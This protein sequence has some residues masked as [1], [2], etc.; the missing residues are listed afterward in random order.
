MLEIVF[1]G[2]NREIAMVVEGI[3]I[4]L[5]WQFS[6]YFS[7]KYYR[8]VKDQKLSRNEL[9][10]ALFFVSFGFTHFFYQ[11]ADYY[12][13]DH[14]FFSFLGYISMGIGI[15][16]FTTH[17]EKIKTIQTKWVFPAITFIILLSFIITYIYDPRL[18]QTLAIILIIPATIIIP[19]FIFR[20]F[21][22]LSRRYQFYTIGLF[23]GLSFILVGNLGASDVAVSIFGT[24]IRILAS[25]LM[26]L[27][28]SLLALFF[29]ILPSLSE[30]NW[31]DKLKYIIII[32]Q[33]GICLYDE[34]FQE[35]TRLNKRLLAAA[36]FNVHEFLD[37]MTK[38]FKKL[39][40]LEKGDEFFIL[41][42]GQQV[43]GVLVTTELLESLKYLLRS[44]VIEFENFYS[45]ILKS[46]NGDARMFLPTSQLTSKIF[47]KIR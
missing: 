2:E 11:F 13:V 21:K 41:E 20:M 33:T 19:Y 12:P 18:P 5:C 23:G 30:L 7:Y 10:W 44:F 3:L 26:I 34:D 42:Y 46:W 35:K 4:L 36:L 1:L 29:N 45:D 6:V 43:I 15:F 24:Y 28:I 22:T 47:K 37:Q 17:L 14:Q 40:I 25:L 9:D 27:G 31:Y 32:D 38:G 16:L 8:N 39:K